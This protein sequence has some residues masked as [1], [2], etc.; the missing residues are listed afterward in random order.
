MILEHEIAIFNREFELQLSECKTLEKLEEI[1]VHF[2]GR[3][4]ILSSLMDQF[5][6]AS[7]EEKRVLG[8]MV[9]QLKNTTH[10]QLEEKRRILRY[11]IFEQEQR[12]YEH[13]DLT[14]YKKPLYRA[15]EHVYTTLIRELEDCF[16]SM[17]FDV[18]DG[19]ELETDHY[20]FGAMNIPTDH[21]ARDAHDTFWVDIPGMLLRTHTSSVQ[22]HQLKNRSLPLAVFAPGRC[23]RNEATDASHDFMFTQA[24]C[25]YVGKDVSMAHLIGTAQHFLKKIIRDENIQ[26]RVRPGYFPFVEPGVEIDASCVFCKQRGCSICKKTGWIELLGAGLV[27]PNVLREAGIDSEEYSG[28]AFGFGIERIAMITYGITDIRFFRSNTLSFLRQF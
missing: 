8:P 11:S 12:Q 19:P 21:P 23:Y 1:R 22:G 25:L 3:K 27:H 7:I 2:L 13:N 15:H 5:K 16:I 20:N 6:K 24:E 18:V 26:M 9:Q 28:F 14:A 10:V 4:G 17:G